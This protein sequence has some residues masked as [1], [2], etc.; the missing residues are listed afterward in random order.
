LNAFWKRDANFEANEEE[1][2][3]VWTACGLCVEIDSAHREDGNELD[4]FQG[5]RLLEKLGHTQTV[6][7]M[8]A[9]LREIDIDFNR[10]ISLTEY[11]IS[12]YLIDWHVLVNASQGDNSEVVARASQALDA[13]KHA[14][15]LATEAENKASEARKNAAEAKQQADDAL[16][17]L[18][19]KEKEHA[20]AIAEK[21]RI[22]ND[23]TLGI[24]KR[25]RAKAE[26][27]QLESQ[28]PMPLRTAK[29][30][31]EATTRKLTKALN[32]A[33]MA[34]S[35]AH[36]ASVNAQ[37]AFA[38]AETAL[39]DAVNSGGSAEGALWWLDREL[40]EAR[41]RMPRHKLKQLEAKVAAAKAEAAAAHA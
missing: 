10:K 29:I 26:K 36:A 1:R 41:K 17:E 35:A 34:E 40:E 32:K 23:D 7:E 12:K 9:H 11:L 24:V 15:D 37:N 25:N 6:Q 4:E 13:A 19:A 8:R 5:H 14:L 3:H 31:Q 39:N 30:H 20:D 28:D 21:D 33:G 38:D 27:A 2:E 18:E 22:A 16:A